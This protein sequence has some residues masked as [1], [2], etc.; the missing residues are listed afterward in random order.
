MQPPAAV[1]TR[2]Y[3][4]PEMNDA[5]AVELRQ[6]LAQLR[7]VREVMVVAAENI[8][9]LK[10]DMQGFDE[11]AVEQLVMISPLPNPPPEGEGAIVKDVKPERR[12]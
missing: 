6:R 2:L 1:R 12:A 3:H 8:A 11:A 7:G 5:A 9:C 4:L 10:V